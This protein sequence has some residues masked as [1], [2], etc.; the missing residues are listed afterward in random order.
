[1]PIS[2]AET[3]RKPSTCW[4]GPPDGILVSAETVKDF[5][6]QP[7]DKVNLRLQSASDHQY[8]VVPFRFIGV[9]REFPTA[10]RDSFLVANADYV[11]RETAA[12]ASEIVLL[13][14]SAP[15]APIAAAA[16]TVVAGLPGLKVSDLGEAQRLI[17][18]SLTAVDLGG[19]T[20]LELGLAVLM[21]ASATGLI[22]AL[23]IADRRRTFAILS[24]LG[25]K[26]RQLGAFLWS[27]ALLLFVAGTVVGTLT[28]FALAWML[29]KLLTGAFDP[30]PEF[31]SVPWLYLG[32]LIA[33]ALVSVAIAVIGALRE[34]RVP[35]VQ[36][37]REL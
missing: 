35:A 34:T 19:M 27:E 21:V 13:K 18:S 33:V 17:G 10:P 37:M 1:M 26:P 31:L 14:T 22:L 6:L 20:R 2:R 7:G 36:R 4:H 29:V 12:G 15:T 3:R 24:A 23:G 28:G 11:G 8:H 30:P 32:A 9:V 25:A 16:R 5:Q